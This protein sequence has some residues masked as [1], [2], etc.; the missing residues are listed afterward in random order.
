MLMLLPLLRTLLLPLLPTPHQ[1]LRDRPTPHPP[2]KM[3]P[4]PIDRRHPA[5][6]ATVCSLPA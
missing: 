1:L 3:P 5:A 2:H 6:P 4:S